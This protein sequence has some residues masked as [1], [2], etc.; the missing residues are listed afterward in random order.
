MK[1]TDERSTPQDKF[2]A[3]N[4]VFAFSLDAAATAENAKCK[5]FFTVEDD[6]LKQDWSTWSER[7][8]FCN[9]PYSRGELARWIRKAHYEATVR[10]VQTVML[11][12]GDTSTTWFHE[13]EQLAFLYHVRGRWRFNDNKSAAKFGT[14]LA[15][16]GF[17]F[18]DMG[19]FPRALQE[20]GIPGYL[21]ITER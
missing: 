3:L 7:R 16:F 13:A 1:E 18:L 12:P 20:A 4:R 9:P 21:H 2:D 15:L 5:R 17:R 14:V 8:V 10:Y 19:H 11:L 6:A